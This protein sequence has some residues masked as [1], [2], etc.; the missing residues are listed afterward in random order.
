MNDIGKKTPSINMYD[1]IIIGAG[2]AG[3]MAA[4]MASGTNTKVLLIEKNDRIGKKL[5]LTG[6]TRCNITNLKTIEDFINEIPVNNKFL[7][8]IINQ[9]GPKDIYDYFIK[10]GIPLKIEDNNRVFPKDNKATTIIET[11]F[12]ELNNK[13][14]IVNLNEVVS[15]II[16]ENDDGYKKIITSKGSYQTNNIIIA[17]GGCSYPQTG[18]TGDGYRFAKSLK[19]KVTSLY[20]VGT[21]LVT[22]ETLPLAGIT[23]DNVIIKFNKKEAEGSLLFTHNGLSGPVIFKI[24]E[25]VAKQI[26]IN[27]GVMIEVDLLPQYNLNNLLNELDKYN[28]KKEIVSFIREYLPKRLA[29]YIV[30]EKTANIKIGSISKS[31][32]LRLLETLKKLPININKTGSLEQSIVTGGGVDIKYINP[33]TMEST[34]NKGIYFIGETLDI[35]GHTGGYNITISLSTG[36]AAGLSVRRKYEWNE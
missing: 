27:K 1:V 29:D 17:T 26:V 32:K 10:L 18:S 30:N 12:K 21:F 33:K 13:N 7:Y 19:Q 36:Y 24:S 22:K 16:I 20:P 23:L 34:I 3:I 11:L 5:S 25:E 14:I 35:H 2:P 8:S 28:P 31:N 15:Q 9:F 6:G 4:I